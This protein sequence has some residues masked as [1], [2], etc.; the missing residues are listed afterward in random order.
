MLKYIVTVALLGTSII[1]NAQQPKKKAA[2]NTYDFVPGETVIFADDFSQDSVGK[3]PSKWKMQFSNDHSG[4]EY[5]CAVQKDNDGYYLEIMEGTEIGLNALIKKDLLGDSFTLE[6][7]FFPLDIQSTAD[8]QLLKDE[9]YL[10]YSTGFAIR[11]NGKIYTWSPYYKEHKERDNYPGVFELNKWHHFAVTYKKRKIKFYIDHY[12]AA[13]FDSSNIS[14]S[15]VYLDFDGPVNVRNVRIAVGEPAKNFDKLLTENKFI[16]HAINFDVNKSVIQPASMGF[17]MQLA[18][19][20]KANPAIKLEID[21][22]TD[23]DGDA[24]ANMQ[25]SQQR[26]KEV[27]KQLVAAGV[28]GDRLTTRGLGATKPLQPNTTL[29]A[30]ANNRRVEFIKL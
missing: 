29:E 23:N 4:T 24:A 11:G 3:F 7:D 10:T 6:Y 13:T 12:H 28:S 15:L 30:K 16:T 19:F 21:G 18:Q 20:L 14:K 5:H 9:A 2:P 1:C 17:V 8:V 25:L 26:A 22:H 27:K